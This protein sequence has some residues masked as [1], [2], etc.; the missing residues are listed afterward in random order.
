MS[1]SDLGFSFPIW[2]AID[3][4]QKEF[5]LALLVAGSPGYG[6][7]FPLFEREMA[8]TIWGES[9]ENPDQKTAAISIADATLLL[10][11]MD[12][13]Q[14]IQ[15]RYVAI[16]PSLTYTVAAERYISFDAIRALLENE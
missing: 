9:I 14:N 4:A 7:V 15:V 1:D 2:T 6:N 8:A 10:Y 12:F 13:Y 5:P 3:S 16:N 11:M